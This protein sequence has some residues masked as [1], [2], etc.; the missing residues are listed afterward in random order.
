MGIVRGGSDTSRIEPSVAMLKR[1]GK[2]RPA[3]ITRAVGERNKSRR[4]Q[5]LLDDL[6]FGSREERRGGMRV[7]W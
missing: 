2:T 7:A 3:A 4:S 6:L 1:F 5:G